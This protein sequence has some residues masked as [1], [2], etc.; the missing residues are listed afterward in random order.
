MSIS[1]VTSRLTV[2]TLVS[3]VAVAEESGFY[4][5]TGGDHLNSGLDERRG[6]AIAPSVDSR[7][8]TFDGLNDSNFGWK[9]FAG[10]RF[11]QFVGAELGFVDASEAS[12][13]FA[14]A[15]M[16]SGTLNGNTEVSEFSGAV[17]G[18]F[19]LNQQFGVFGKLGAAHWD[20]DGTA[21]TTV[22]GTA[23]SVLAKGSGT[24]LLL[25]FGGRYN[26]ND[27]TV[28]KF[29]WEHYSDIRLG[30]TGTKTDVNVFGGSLQY[31]F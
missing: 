28:F 11:N 18:S 12:A 17:T 27:Q 29:E 6:G 20:V 7:A 10:F 3:A 8:V 26:F 5:D 24:N 2:L 25:S 14:A 22:G 13:A 4:L 15:T 23:V 30:N 31:R 19:P 1:Q 16:E 21:T 9:V